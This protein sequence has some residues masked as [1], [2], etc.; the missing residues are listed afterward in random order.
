M[1]PAPIRSL[2]AFIAFTLIFAAALFLLSYTIQ[3]SES[4]YLL[5][6]Y[7]VCFACFFVLSDIK[8]SITSFIFSGLFLRIVLL[9]SLPNLSQDFYRF[10]WDGQSLLHGIN[11]YSNLP[12]DMMNANYDLLPNQSLL[13]NGMGSL[14]AMHYSNYPPVNQLFF[15]AAAF[16]AGSSLIWNVFC[17]KLFIIAADLGIVFFGRKLLKAFSLPEKNI[18]LY[19]LNPLVIIEGTGNLHFEPVMVF[20]LV[21]GLYFLQKNKRF[22][23]ATAM[24]LSVL[25]KLIPLMVLPFIFRLLSVKKSISFY[26]INAAI[27]ILSFALFFSGS[28]ISHYGAT[29]S[30]WFVNF[31]FNASVYYL[32]RNAG[33]AITGYNTIGVLG[34]ILPFI[35]TVAIMYFALRKKFNSLQEIFPPL[36]LA[37]SIYFFLS[38]TVH[39]WYIITLLA[40]SVFTRYRYIL[41]WTCT[42]F[43]SYLAYKSF[44]VK[45]YAWVLF[46]EYLPVFIYMIWEIYKKPKPVIS[47]P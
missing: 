39:P 38:T 24:A 8:I 17:L 18:F 14:S 35:S 19:F 15:L 26:L 9:F 22:V 31:E 43:L 3:R 45:E 10:I 29:V 32:L 28:L 36:L 47:D 20:F 1:K 27:I 30:L 42:I 13:Y 2:V 4:L 44:E 46:V 23:S 40:L 21:A 6:L 16:V 41:V 11:P 25:V 37:L 33:Y 34:K 12:K 5:E 7:L